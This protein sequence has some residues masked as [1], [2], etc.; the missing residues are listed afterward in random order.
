MTR[1]PNSHNQQAPVLR[2]DR[3]NQTQFDHYN[4]SA[5]DQADAEGVDIGCAG[6]VG[7]GVLRGCLSTPDVMEELVLGRSK[8]DSGSV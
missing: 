7:Q 4:R 5:R 1:V 8:I 3:C 6:I 2:S